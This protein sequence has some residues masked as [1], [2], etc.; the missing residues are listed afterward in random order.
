M[1]N[2][3]DSRN[4]DAYTG[5][6][7]LSWQID[8]HQIWHSSQ[9]RPGGSNHVGFQNEEA[10]RLIE[11][12]H[13]TFDEEKRL[14]LLHRFHRLIHEEQPYLFLIAPITIVAWDDRIENVNF[15]KIRPHFLS[16]DWYIQP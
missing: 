7:G 13:V 8:P 11:E 4:F 10:D 2:A 6:W 12:L 1:Q 9:I 15:A 16:F 5:G 3:I 14:D